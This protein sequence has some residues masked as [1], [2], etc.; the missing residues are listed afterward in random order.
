MLSWVVTLRSTLRRTRK[1]HAIRLFR[2][3][4]FTSSVSSY[5]PVSPSLMFRTFFQV[6][7]PASPLF[8]ILTKTPGV[9]GYSSHFGTARAV[10]P[11]GTP[12]IIQV[13]SFH[14]LTHSFALFCI[15][16]KINSFVFKQFRTL[17]QKHPGGGSEFPFLGRLDVGTFRCAFCIPN[18]VTG[19]SPIR[20]IAA[21]RL[22]CHNPQRYEIS[23]R[24]GETTPLLPVS[25]NSERTSGTV[26][27]RFRSKTPIRSGL[28]ADRLTIALARRPGS[29]VLTQRAF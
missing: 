5:P 24:S 20:P 10:L 16:K 25:K 3:P 17:W 19:R 15:R 1:S 9:W 21:K 11:T 6:P 2:A 14:V 28:R 12:Y 22:W 4:S 7:Y 29:T 13:L 27:R 8:A 26:H 18:G 23:S